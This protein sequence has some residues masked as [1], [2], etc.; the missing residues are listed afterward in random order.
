MVFPMIILLIMLVKILATSA[1]IGSGGIGGVFAPTL[2]LGGFAGYFITLILNQ[3]GFHVS[4]QNFVLAGMAGMMAGVMHSPMTAIFL[5]AEIT[6]GVWSIYSPYDN[7][8]GI[9]SYHQPT[10]TSFHLS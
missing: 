3:N 1:T 4:T 6:G 10:G 2:F 5:I 7:F 9:L 8:S